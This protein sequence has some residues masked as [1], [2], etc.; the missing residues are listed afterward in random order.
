MKL[1]P[2]GKTMLL[3]RAIDYLTKFSVLYIRSPFRVAGQ[4]SLRDSPNN[5]GYFCFLWLPPRG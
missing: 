4:V 1:M 3:P 2:L 5:I